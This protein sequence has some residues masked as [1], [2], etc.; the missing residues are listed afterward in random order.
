MEKNYCLAEH[1]NSTIY[2]ENK[3]ILYKSGS[4]TQVP[5]EIRATG[6]TTGFTTIIRKNIYILYWLKVAQKY[7]AC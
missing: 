7:W 2:L 5:N 6:I 1:K 4:K 3:I